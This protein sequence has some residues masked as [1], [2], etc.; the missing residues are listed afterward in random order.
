ML[1]MSYRLGEFMDMTVSNRE[2]G[3]RGI[4][5]MLA[6]L[7]HR[8]WDRLLYSSKKLNMLDLPA[9]A[10]GRSYFA[11]SRPMFWGLMLMA[12]GL[13]S[14]ATQPLHASP[15][16]TDSFTYA[17]GSNLESQ[18]GGSVGPGAFFTS[19]WAVS[20][21]TPVDAFTVSNGKVEVGDTQGV[22]FRIERGLDLSGTSNL[23]CPTLDPGCV[24]SPMAIPGTVF[25]A[26][27]MTQVVDNHAAYEM[28]VEF[29]DS[30]GLTLAFGIEN[31][32]IDAPLGGGLFD[33]NDY[34]FATLGD[35]RVLSTVAADPGTPNYVIT[36][37][38]LDDSVGGQE[39]LRVWI[40]A[41][42]NDVINGLNADIDISRD[43][44]AVAGA[45]GTRGSLGDT[46]ILAANTNEANRIKTFD[47]VGVFKD[48]ELLQVP[49]IDLGN[50]IVQTAFDE[51]NVGAVAAVDFSFQFNS[52]VYAPS[53]TPAIVTLT[54]EAIA[55]ATNV[56]PF[57]QTFAAA[58]VADDLRRD[59]AGADGGIRLIVS[60][61]F[62]DSFVI[63][64]FHYQSTDN[65]EVDVY[66]SNDG[67]VS[68]YFSGSY[69]PAGGTSTATE[70]MLL[71]DNIGNGGADIWVEYRPTVAGA[72]VSLNGLQFVPEPG[73]GLLLGLGLMGLGAVR[74]RAGS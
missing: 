48:I 62:E 56:V 65:S 58:G 61:L 33:H 7:S 44:D 2:F 11:T 18:S 12:L 60:G 47:D 32:G 28:S 13:A 73:T 64:T 14:L 36:A 40:N 54:V 43:L 26:A 4:S 59:G 72:T 67:G 23:G 51:W 17:E 19:S 21:A 5:M 25:V 15:M 27:E 8:E 35:T 37:L 1:S 29:T 24:S 68:F 45:T 22:D 6:F 9:L 49:R 70:H 71:V 52:G 53:V 46:M 39:R 3:T 16:T 34:F 31:D 41:D 42:W 55:A 69:I 20:G 50:S 74:R 63:K 57:T 66:I 10:E 30:F 38:T